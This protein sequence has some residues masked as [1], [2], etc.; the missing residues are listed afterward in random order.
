MNGLLLEWV[1]NDGWVIISGEA[2]YAP[3]A[4]EQ[5]PRLCTPQTASA[6]GH[7]WRLV[8]DERALTQD[9]ELHLPPAE[10]AVLSPAVRRP[11]DSARSLSTDLTNCDVRSPN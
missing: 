2:N 4:V 5:W 3:I 10:A 8:E 9:N 1:E 7:L 11:T 6:I